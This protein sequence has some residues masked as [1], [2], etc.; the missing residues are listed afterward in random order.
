MSDGRRPHLDTLAVACLLLCSAL[1]GVNQSASKVAVAEIPPLLQAALRSAGAAVLLG[2][3]TWIRR[4]DLRPGGK[5]VATVRGGLLA[6]ALFA[7]E[8][9]CIFVGLQYTTAS[10]MAVFIYLAPFFVALGMPFIAPGERL[11]GWQLAG[12]LLAFAG[13][14]T[15]FGDS[16]S[17]RAPANP[18]QWWGDTLGV[19]AAALWAGTTLTI[20]ATPLSSAPAE[21]TLMYQL[22]VSALLLG[23]ATLATGEGWP[24]HASVLAWGSLVF[25]TVIVTFASYLLWFWLV[26]HYPATQISSFT[27]LTPIFGLAAGVGLL[28]EPLTPRLVLAL[29]AV[30]GGI[31][32]VSRRRHRA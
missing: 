15:A 14:A 12:L 8:F 18:L 16:F 21:Q 27:L 6:G 7:L 24:H 30:V 4:I 2:L 29:A 19:L 28:G 20:R 26:R 10:R 31:A 1:W 3:F 5:T 32:L 22:V 11:R 23:G 13:V 9:G 25:Q 17:G